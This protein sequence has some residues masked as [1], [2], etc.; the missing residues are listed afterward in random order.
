MTM[1]NTGGATTAPRTVEVPELLSPAEAAR[2][3][4]STTDSLRTLRYTGRGPAFVKVGARVLY[5]ASDL[6]AYCERNTFTCTDGSR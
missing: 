5:R 3:L 4:H 2:Y 1:N 6:I